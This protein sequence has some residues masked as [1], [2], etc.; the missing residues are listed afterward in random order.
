MGNKKKLNKKGKKDKK[1]IGNN[2]DVSLKKK[3]VTDKLAKLAEQISALK[4]RQKGLKQQ[5]KAQ[6]QEYTV[7]SKRYKGIEKHTTSLLQ[8]F[9]KLQS[10]SQAI[11]NSLTWEIKDA[12]TNRDRLN[13]LES[14]HG[15]DHKQ[16]NNLLQQMEQQAGLLDKLGNRLQTMEPLAS[17]SEQQAQQIEHLQAGNS[18]LK[19]DMGKLI[20]QLSALQHD[21]QG[22]GS[23]IESLHTELDELTKRWQESSGQQQQL[24][25]SIENLDRAGSGVS[26]QLEQLLIT[27]QDLAGQTEKLDQASRSNAGSL[28]ALKERLRRFM[29]QRATTEEQLA[30]KDAELEKKSQ[31]LGLQHQ[32]LAASHTRLARNVL[33]AGI[34]FLAI[35]AIAYWTKLSPLE[36]KTADSSQQVERI[37]QQMER[38]EQNLSST[39]EQGKADQGLAAEWDARFEQIN[40]S[41]NAME[42]NLTTLTD[43]QNEIIAKLSRLE[44]EREVID[45][46]LELNN[47]LLSELADQQTET[48]TIVK[49]QQQRLAPTKDKSERKPAQEKTS[50]ATAA[51]GS[52][53]NSNWLQGLNPKHYT[54]QIVAAYDAALISRVAARKDLR[55]TVAIYKGEFN[56]REWN[57][58]LYGDFSTLR[59]ARA[60]IHELPVD[61]LA[62]SPWVRKLSSVQS[63]L[64]K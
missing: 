42:T 48:Q 29:A 4:T 63:D 3:A 57:I 64:A 28:Q 41:Q 59:E 8:Q 55:R 39:R 35:G 20:T 2:K 11:K 12:A 43:E 7:L 37:S 46:Q 54:I 51:T 14:H 58:L 16:L 33:V 60:A 49:Q 23:G 61:I 38:H 44:Q 53:R 22:F 26:Q 56:Q 18:G 5:W 50:N 1:S 31:H 40:Q 45:E 32:Q 19:S 34:L 24:E 47:R 30:N 25:T 10:E 6:R 27:I 36:Q 15:T 21:N 62:N 52:V 9:P 17:R 13:A